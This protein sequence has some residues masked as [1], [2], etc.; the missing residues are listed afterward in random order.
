MRDRGKLRI[1]IKPEQEFAVRYKKGSLTK[2]RGENG[3]EVAKR[4]C[5]RAAL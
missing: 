4:L 3:W 1:P 5:T 2:K